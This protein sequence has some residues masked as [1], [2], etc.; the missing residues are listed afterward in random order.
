MNNI[1]DVFDEKIGVDGYYQ[2]IRDKLFPKSTPDSIDAA[3]FPLQGQIFRKGST[4]SRV[5][6]I[7]DEKIP[8]FLEGHV[9][10]DEFYPPKSHKINIPQGRF[11][12]ASTRTL[13]LA[14]HPFVAMKECDIKAGNYFLHSYIKLSTDMCFFA[15]EQGRDEFS[16]M[17]YKLLQSKDTKFYSVIN[18]VNDD[19]LKFE[20]FQ[21]IAYGSVKVSEGHNDQTWGLINTTKN[22]AMSGEYIKDT[23]L[24]VAWL[25]YCDE[26]GAIYQ[27]ALFKPLSNKKKNKL[28][29]INFRDNKGLFVR[30]STKTM[31]D[32]NEGSRK[33]KLLLEKGY[34]S[35]FTQSPIKV[36]WK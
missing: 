13:Y 27:H 28:T 32:L 23:E 3:A 2:I 1:F 34:Y 22:L 4:F 24:S 12:G 6:Y 31:N 10:R 11:N 7:S 5:R 29:R 20:G 8:E 30:E 25:S 9:T 26:K 19:I 36:L 21:G 16:D 35:E 17:I 14:D 18:R 33:T 15:V